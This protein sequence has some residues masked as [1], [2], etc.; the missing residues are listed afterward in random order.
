MGEIEARVKLFVFD[1]EG[2]WE[3]QGIF[4]VC[5][6][7]CNIEI[8]DEETFEVRYKF[9]IKNIVTH[10]QNES[11]ICWMDKQS[12]KYALSF[13]KNEDAEIFWLY[14]NKKEESTNVLNTLP[15][16]T[17]ENIQKI[18]EAFSNDGAF[19][20]I[21]NSWLETLCANV[22]KNKE[23]HEKLSQFFPVFKRL[24]NL[25]KFNV[26]EGLLKNPHFSAVFLVIEADPDKCFNMNFCGY[27]H[28]KVKFV[29]FLGISDQLLIDNI[30]LAFRVLCLKESLMSFSFT[31][32]TNAALINF[33]HTI[34]DVVIGKYVSMAEVRMELLNKVMSKDLNAFSFINEVV[35]NSKFVGLGTRFAL[36][37]ALKS[38]EIL[39]YMGKA[40][41][42]PNI[43]KNVNRIIFDTY[44]TIAIV[45]TKIIFD[46]FLKDPSFFIRLF[47]ESADSEMEV[48]HKSCELLKELLKSDYLLTYDHFFKG[49]YEE[50]LPYF[51][52]KIVPESLNKD[53]VECYE[54]ILQ[55][56]EHCILNDSV[57]IRFFIITKNFHNVLGE[58]LKCDYKTLKI[59]VFQVIK[60]VI[61]RKDL[62]L[63]GN[64]IRTDIISRVL[65]LFN[66]NSN[67]ENMIFSSTLSLFEAIK[68]TKYNKLIDYSLGLLNKAH[69]SPILQIFLLG[70]HKG[71]ESDESKPDST[72]KT[73]E[74]QCVQ[75]SATE[76]QLVRKR[77]SST[78]EEPIKKQSL[79]YD[80]D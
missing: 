15:E 4:L 76:D 66:E 37:T 7:S 39:N 30:N 35:E 57:S 36:Y 5:V 10:R 3:D 48:F 54:D 45:D 12:I 13:Q 55:I 65:E 52:L 56:F 50:I 71:G 26:Y 14:L 70:D 19:E 64:L 67:K 59:T 16:P 23:T 8:Q 72:Q 73:P 77:L 9:E 42:H 33:Y 6:E 27:F 29:N 60:S 18:I 20:L 74:E 2:E 78:Y 53:L 51:L 24:I 11:I 34:W 40:W 31:E 80:T 47:K 1:S 43:G 69:H 28:T 61:L 38:D 68:S 46:I 58:L 75:S 41:N 21:N 79:D 49:F 62:F 22:E 44:Y 17:F 32:E 25:S 63:I